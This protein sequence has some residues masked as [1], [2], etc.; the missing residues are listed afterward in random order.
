MSTKR[1]IIVIVA[2]AFIAVIA[3]AAQGTLASGNQGLLRSQAPAQ[4]ADRLAEPYRALPS[5]A[6]EFSDQRD[7]FLGGAFGELTIDAAQFSD[8]RDPWLGEVLGELHI[9]AA[10]FSDQRDPY[11]GERYGSTP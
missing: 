2:A 1:V 6:A 9:D 4:H 3:F 10:Q 8:Q 11:L 5:N 7:P